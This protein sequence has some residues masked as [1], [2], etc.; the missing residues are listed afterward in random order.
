M[1]RLET[2]APG[3]L[4]V[5][6]E[7]GLSGPPLRFDVEG[8]RAAFE[9]PDEPVTRA[10]ASEVGQALLAMARDPRPAVH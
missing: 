4:S 2:L 6:L 3:G 8:I 10:F 7:E 1:E 5:V 9:G